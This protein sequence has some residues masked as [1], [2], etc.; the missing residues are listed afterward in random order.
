MDQSQ[1]WNLFS[2]L[3]ILPLYSSTFHQTNVENAQMVPKI[4]FES[5]EFNRSIFFSKK[6]NM[7]KKR[8]HLCWHWVSDG[9][10]IFKLNIS[11][12]SF[13][14]GYSS[15]WWARRST[16]LWFCFSIWSTN[17]SKYM[18][19]E[20]EFF[21][22]FC[23]LLSSYSVDQVVTDLFNPWE[24]LTHE[25]V[26]SLFNDSI[27]NFHPYSLASYWLC[28]LTR[29]QFVCSLESKPFG[30]HDFSYLGKVYHDMPLHCICSLWELLSV[31]YH[32]ELSDIN[33]C[34]N[35]A[36]VQFLITRF[37]CESLSTRSLYFCNINLLVRDHQS[38][39]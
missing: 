19:F 37:C 20:R 3:R 27:P 30:S 29:A 33:R 9:R 35:P 1:C 15:G 32:E 14:D 25:W 31:L 26:L 10:M 17:K 2:F 24:I 8:T 13:P 7:T 16:P 22:V 28:L 34:Q 6:L 5:P 4:I 39:V 38:K 18:R 23:S 11:P 21:W 36:S 12:S